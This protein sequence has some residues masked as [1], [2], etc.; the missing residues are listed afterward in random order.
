[1]INI[2]CI[3]GNE[4]SPERLWDN[5]ISRRIPV[6]IESMPLEKRWRAN[7][8]TDTYLKQTAGH[9]KVSV[10]YR[11]SISEGFGLGKRRSMLFKEFL[12][13]LAQGQE[14][15]YITSP[16]QPIGPYGFPDVMVSPILELRSSLPVRLSWAGNL[17]PQQINMWMGSSADGTSSGLHHDY[18]DNFY[19]LLRGRKKFRLF[20]PTKASMMYTHGDIVCVYPNGRIVYKGQEGIQE[21]GSHEADVKAWKLNKGT[22]QQAFKRSV[23]SEYNSKNVSATVLDRD[24]PPS[25][26]RVDMSLP[27]DFLSEKYPN[28]PFESCIEL[29]VNAGETLYL[30]AGWFHEVI[31]I[32]RTA[33]KEDLSGHL[34]INYWL[35][36][37]DNLKKGEKGFCKP[38]HQ[39]FWNDVWNSGMIRLGAEKTK[40][41]HIHKKE[42]KKLFRFRQRYGKLWLWYLFKQKRTRH[43]I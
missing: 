23:I 1:M 36:P 9:A 12:H 24:T 25:F 4:A 6:V 21:D 41:H 39:E 35:H 30:P 17:V 3:S 5:Y 2:D 37:P 15:L 31:S 38:Y 14:N 42:I 11:S 43:V 40:K 19:M 10:E 16:E 8:W 26:S 22:M 20:P 32:N 27:K 33:E 7:L 34:A 18:H 13:R 29:T 28:F